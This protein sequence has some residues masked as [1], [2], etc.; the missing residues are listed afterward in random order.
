MEV[1]SYPSI[2]MMASPAHRGREARSASGELEDRLEPL[3]TRVWH[4]IS[5][6][7]WASLIHP[8][9]ECGHDCTGVP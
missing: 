4:E 1:S 3:A 7:T 2:R 8:P 6:D 5:L 9:G